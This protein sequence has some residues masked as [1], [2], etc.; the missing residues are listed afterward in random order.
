[1]THSR[2][3]A[4]CSTPRRDLMPFH[5]RPLLASLLVLG[6]LMILVLTPMGPPRVLAQEADTDVPIV[7][8][9]GALPVDPFTGQAT[10]SIPLEVPPGATGSNPT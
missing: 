10:T 2:S 7:H 8:V 1:M 4:S 5:I 6:V 9:G 3:S